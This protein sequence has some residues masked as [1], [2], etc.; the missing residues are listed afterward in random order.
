MCVVID[1]NGEEFNV[2]DEVQLDSENIRDTVRMLIAEDKLYSM[3]RQMKK[4]RK[5]KTNI[6]NS[7][8]KK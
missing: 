4:Y 3:R 6:F 8:F 5:R 2:P 7:I 1:V